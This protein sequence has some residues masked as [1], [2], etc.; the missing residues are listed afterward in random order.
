VAYIGRS[1]IEEM[2]RHFTDGFL[3]ELKSDEFYEY[4]INAIRSGESSISIYEK[5]VERNIDLRWVEIIENTIIPLDNIIRN[6]M[7]FIK[8]E[9]EIVPI[10]MVRNVTTESIRH[11][12]QHTSMIAQ[13]KG[14][15][16]TPS[17]ML[18]II[19]E[20]SFE[21][22]E[23][24]FIYTLINKLEYFLDKRLQALKTSKDVIDR[25]E[26]GLNGKFTAGHDKVT[27]DISIICETPHVELE[28]YENLIHADT[29]QMNAMQRIERVRKIL[30]NFKA[31][32]LIK[33]LTGCA[34]VRPPLNMT[35]VLTKNQNFKKAV[36]LWIFVESYDDVGYSISQ[37]DRQ[38]EP[39]DMYMN[40]L[41]SVLTM[42][43]IVMKKNSGNMQDLGD[44][45]QRQTENDPN[46]VKKDIDEFIDT[47]D[48]DIEEIRRIFI[49]RIQK[50]IKKQK[51]EYKKIKDVL[52]RA[53]TLETERLKEESA[54]RKERRRKEEEQLKKELARQAAEEQKR[55]AEEL[56]RQRLEQEELE[57][58]K[59]EQEE[60]ERQQ[61][62][63][64]ERLAA[65]EAARAEEEAAMAAEEVA[66]AEE[67]TDAEATDVQEESIESAE[68]IEE[69]E[70]EAAEE[71][72]KIAPDDTEEAVDNDVAEENH[73]DVVE[74]EASGDIA[75]EG[76]EET[77]EA[78]SEE[79]AEESSETADDT[80]D[81]V[82]EETEETAEES[83]EEP[84]EETVE[85]AEK[86][87][88][89]VLEQTDK[90]VTAKE[91][92]E[93]A[94]STDE[95][96][97]EE[98]TEKNS[99]FSF[100]DTLSKVRA[101][102]TRKPKA[103]D[104]ESAE[105]GKAV[106]EETESEE[107]TEDVV[108]NTPVE[109]AEST[110]ESTE[111][112][113]EAAEEAVE[114]P[115]EETVETAE[116]PT[117]EVLEQTD[118]EVI[119]EEPEETAEATD[120]DTAEEAT[121]KNSRFSFK[122]IL[123]KVRAIFTRKPKAED[124]ESAEEGKAVAEET[125]SEE[126]TEDVVENTP[127]EEAE[128]TVESTES[129]EEA[130]EEAVENTEE[131]EDATEEVT[132][133]TETE[134]SA[135]EAN[136]ESP[137]ADEETKA[138]FSLK[139]F[140]NKIKDKI[141][142]RSAAEEP[143]MTS[144]ESDVEDESP[145]EI[146]SHIEESDMEPVFEADAAEYDNTD[147][148]KETVYEFYVNEEDAS[149]LHMTAEGGYV[150]DGEDGESQPEIVYGEDGVQSIY[151][152]GILF[153]K[154]KKKRKNNSFRNKKYSSARKKPRHKRRINKNK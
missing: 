131:T 35:N 59:L 6:P 73:E 154:I 72:D 117:E 29:T 78:V 93:T 120:E 134:G 23:N 87:T 4:F 22:Y 50:K 109:E 19:K 25:L 104:E 1:K 33:A 61:R 54:I 41:F 42:Q 85:A 136:E 3:N 153:V 11:L 31:S 53:I 69:K 46:V 40:E 86:P 141:G 142:K 110:V 128:S 89:E 97:A 123:S 83:V 13:V 21:T 70:N 96:T 74:N 114:E 124:E 116:K 28:E 133:A 84:A 64:A 60:L 146:N 38:V 71:E 16:V 95:D 151:V 15:E 58:Q 44:Y 150:Y 126:K 82:A 20:E 51:T 77:N 108:E 144:E 102:F 30:Y 119:A 105:E 139:S 132:E 56:E 68:E 130:A 80:I 32:A 75:E 147:A 112:A 121:E 94:E 48:L 43:Y 125:E 45:G 113:E 26:L 9:E 98:A 18:N 138:K 140:M 67:I 99:R 63:E 37:V 79:S 101:I 129:A 34:M 10:E 12:A 2:Y 5:Y 118:K 145:E 90:E 107:K 137:Q 27:Y 115:A 103:E 62:E 36:E 106:A 65:L 143:V 100:K 152:N 92:E 111:S 57:R 149:K 8:N 7:R 52:S 24:R 122:D 148:P 81:N 14:D 47:F 55:L 17:R 88:D 49:D 127:V 39:T 91:P 135:E 76:N 66:E